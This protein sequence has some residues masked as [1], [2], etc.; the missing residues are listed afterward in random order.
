MKTATL[1]TT[2]WSIDKVHSK[3]QFMVKHLMITT[4]NGSFKEY[5][6]SVETENDDLTTAKINF[7]ADANSVDTGSEHRDTHLKSDDFFAAEKFPK[8][9]FVSTKM[10]KK[11]DEHYI[12]EGNLTIRE[13]TK[14]ITLN[15]EFG[16]IAKDPWGGT[17][18]G[19]NVTG[20]VNRKDF[21][22]NWNALTEAGGMLV[23][24]EVRINCS[25]QFVR[26]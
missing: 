14:P 26:A 6:S 18:A 3:I 24:E 17:R 9:S 2:K 19:F 4:V 15:V 23:S 8:L 5:E 16:G 7:S 1:T 10:T 21:G 22:L 13:I 12:L 20:K 11:D 25:V